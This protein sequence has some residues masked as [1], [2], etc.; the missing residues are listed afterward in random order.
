MPFADVNGIEIYHEVHGSGPRLLYISGTGNDLRRS[1]AALL[2]VTRA[3]ETLAYDQRGLG[4]TSSSPRR[5]VSHLARP[6][7]SRSTTDNGPV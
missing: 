6:A 1:P 7:P 2:P 4:Q 3:F 5:R